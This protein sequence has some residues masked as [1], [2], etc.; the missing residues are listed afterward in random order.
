M[1]LAKLR[2]WLVHQ[3][4]GAKDSQRGIGLNEQAFARPVWSRLE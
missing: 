1:D 3:V 4:A 2:T